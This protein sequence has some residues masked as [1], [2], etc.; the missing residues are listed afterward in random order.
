MGDR[1]AYEHHRETIYAVLIEKVVAS[2]V[3]NLIQVGIDI[4]ES[5]SSIGLLGLYM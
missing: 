4:T 3:P 5:S 2:E 1:L